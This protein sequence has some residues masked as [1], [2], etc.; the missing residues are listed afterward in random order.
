[1][2]GAIETETARLGFD[3]I[4]TSTDA[5]ESILIHRGWD[6]YGATESLRGPLKIYRFEV[7]G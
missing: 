6:L 3:A 4:Y 7:G 1:L 2:V 5:A